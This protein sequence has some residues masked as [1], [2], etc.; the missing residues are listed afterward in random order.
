MAY[1]N[2]GTGFRAPSVFELY[3][4]G[5]HGGVAAFQQDNPSLEPERTVSFDLGLRIRRAA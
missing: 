1:S 4:N 2:L 5:Q 3:A